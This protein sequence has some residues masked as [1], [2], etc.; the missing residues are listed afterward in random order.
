MLTVTLFQLKQKKLLDLEKEQQKVEAVANRKRSSRIGEKMARRKEE[1]ESA[2]EVRIKEDLLR[3][4]QAGERK[5]YQVSNPANTLTQLRIFT[6]IAGTR[7]SSGG[8]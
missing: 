2:V 4:A 3:K 6:Y 5:K 1:E 7:S 8:T